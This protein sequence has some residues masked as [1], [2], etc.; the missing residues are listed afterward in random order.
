MPEGQPAD[1]AAEGQR[2]GPRAVQPGH[3]ARPAAE[4][5]HRGRDREDQGA[6]GGGHPGPAAVPEARAR[7]GVKVPRLVVHNSPRSN[8]TWTELKPCFSSAEF[9]APRLRPADAAPGGGTSEAR[10]GCRLA[11]PPSLV[12]VALTEWQDPGAFH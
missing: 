3:V 10:V 12:L 5:E 2:G 4:H 9:Q 1:A 7:V 11:A 8:Q 6:G